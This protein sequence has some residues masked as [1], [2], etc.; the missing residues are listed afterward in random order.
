MQIVSALDVHRRQITFKTLELASGESA[1]GR[2]SPAAREPLRQWLERFAGL[3]G[4]F[5]LEGTTGWRFVVEEIERA[6]HVVRLADPRVAHPRATAQDVDRSAHGLAAAA[7]GAALPSG[8]ATR[9]EAAHRRRTR[10][11]RPRRVVSRG[12]RGRRA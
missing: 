2:I 3:Q 4:E 11:A 10:C 9:L 8:R 12:T 5:V 6:G 7:A 1:R